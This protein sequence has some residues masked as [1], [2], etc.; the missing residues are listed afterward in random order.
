MTRRVACAFLLFVAVFLA[1]CDHATKVM[2]KTSLKG[3]VTIVP[4]VFDLQYAEN[5]DT[6]FSLL[7]RHGLGEHPLMLGLI[8]SAVLVIVT[9]AWWR[10][11]RAP[12]LEQLGYAAALGG[13]LGNVTDR[14]FQGYVVDFM[15]LHRWPVFNVADMAVVA[16]VMLIAISSFR[17]RRLAPPA[18]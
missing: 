9:A 10:R 8:S 2:A 6:A 14:L 13:A 17:E 1:G 4:G 15:H 3:I 18:G 16:G 5:R 11:R 12:F 7:S